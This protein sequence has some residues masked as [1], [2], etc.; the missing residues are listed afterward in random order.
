MED[1]LTAVEPVEVG[2][3]VDAVADLPSREELLA[4]L[5]GVMIAAPRT[6]PSRAVTTLKSLTPSDACALRAN[7]PAPAKM[8]RPNI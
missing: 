5:L 7:A 8:A 6:V 2:I 4:R 1:R 3:Q